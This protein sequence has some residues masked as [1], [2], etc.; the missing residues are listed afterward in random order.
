MQQALKLQRRLLVGPVAGSGA[1]RLAGRMAD[2][3]AL[4]GNVP[5]AWW[6]DYVSQTA[7]MNIIVRC[8]SPTGALSQFADLAVFL[9]PL[10]C[11]LA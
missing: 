11:S 4:E 8:S 5:G 3:P 7:A 6:E 9:R 10:R 1:R 2:E